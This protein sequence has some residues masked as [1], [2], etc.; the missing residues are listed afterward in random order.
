M[1][2]W[3]VIRGRGGLFD[4][5][6]Q[7]GTWTQFKGAPTNSNQEVNTP[8]TASKQKC[9][10]K[11]DWETIYQHCEALPI[12]QLKAD[13]SGIIKANCMAHIVHNC[14]K[15]AG[16]MLNVDI[17]FVVN[18]IFSHFSVSAQRTE[19]LK[20]V[21]AFV[22]EDFHVVRRHVPTRWL[23]LWPAVQRLHD[24]WAVIKSY[25]LSLGEDQCPKALWQ[26]LKM[27]QD[28][29]GQPLE[30]Q[31]YLAFLN[32]VLKIFHDVVLLL[33]AQ[34]VTVCELYDVTLTLKTKLQQREIDCFYGMETSAILQQFPEQ[35]AAT[36]KHDFSNFYKMALNYLEKWYDKN[37]TC[38]AL[39]SSF[40]FS[41]LSDAMKVLQ[42]GGKL[43]MD[44]L[45]EEYCVTLPSQQEIV[46]RKAPVVEKWAILL[47]STKTPN[48]T[49]VAS[50]LFS[51][52]ITSASVER[53]F[54]LM[55][56]AWTDQRNRCPVE[57]IKGE[58]QVKTN[59]EYS[60]KEFYSFAL[61]QKALL[62]AAR[63]SKKYKAKRNI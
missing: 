3:A 19:E 30:L 34:D 37:V 48:L 40:T 2:G 59:F 29:E 9:S 11:K 53:V 5:V 57:L 18:K 39:K 13:N 22:E 36:I 10:H 47:K 42:I 60:C 17:D 63:S 4:H 12:I 6:N 14:A 33:E 8:P 25:F 50:F 21:F 58:I 35:K 27:D 23:S 49:A 32:N 44:E 20:A 26:L 43:D 38:L 52:P 54:S 51:I 28:S 15:H 7:T 1:A 56:A 45:Y 31:A 41:Q 16:D 24:S 62:E 61:K 55:T 46:E